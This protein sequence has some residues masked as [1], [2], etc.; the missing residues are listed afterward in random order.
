YVAAMAVSRAAPTVQIFTNPPSPQ[1][2]GTVI[3]IAVAA[4][5]EGEPEKY[6]PLLRYRFSIAD[7]GDTF[8]IVRDFSSG[9][10]FAWRP[11]LYEHDAR[12]KVTVLNTKTKQ[13]SDAETPFR[14]IP[15]VSGENPVAL[16]TAHP[17]VALSS[18][19]A[20]PDGSQFRVAFQRRGETTMRRTGLSP[21][22]ASHTSNQYVAGM[23][24]DSDYTLRTEILTGD[25][26]QT[27]AAVEFRTGMVNETFGRFS[28]AVPPG[29]QASQSEPFILFNSPGRRNMASFTTD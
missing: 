17:L 1:P 20:C 2:V 10:E 7:Q 11:E 24:P 22:H 3:G 26:T 23:R 18:S 9:S 5:D 29:A 19:P 12:V 8:R 25:R 13:T 6:L 4:K 15:R 16:H 21:C 14:I 28:V 27:G